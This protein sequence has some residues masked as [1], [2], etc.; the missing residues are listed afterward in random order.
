MSRR[1]MTHLVCAATVL[2]AQ[3]DIP[4]SEL[5]VMA[6]DDRRPV[7]SGSFAFVRR[8]LYTGTRHGED[9]I[10]QVAIKELKSGEERKVHK[11]VR[12]VEL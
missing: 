3:Y 8:G 11:N 9:V 7:H 2:P 1:L 10:A 6:T 4:P 12:V 5:E